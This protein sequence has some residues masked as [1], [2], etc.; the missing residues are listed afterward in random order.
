DFLQWLLDDHFTLM[1][2]C[3]HVLV[4][5]GNK[6]LSKLDT[7]TALG[8]Y[9][10]GEGQRKLLDLSELPQS[11]QE[12][13][14][15]KKLLLLGKTSTVST[16]HRPAYKDFIVVKE[17]DSQGNVIGAHRFL[18]LYASVAYNSSLKQIPLL[19]Q[20]LNTILLR[21]GFPP[22]GHDDR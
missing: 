9:K 21:A 16:V 12:V 3:H 7:R 14:F 5:D 13:V 17:F 2:Y 4:E 1:G 19:R 8:T 22:K 15:S 18:G 10:K 6:L 11:V 20:K